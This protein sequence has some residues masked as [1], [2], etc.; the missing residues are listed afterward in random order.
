MSSYSYLGAREFDKS[1][2]PDSVILGTGIFGILT[3]S[4]PI[5]FLFLFEM[6]TLFIQGLIGRF[7]QSTLTPLAAQ[8]TTDQCKTG[9][10]AP[11]S[12]DRVTLLKLFGE[13][14]SFPSRP[15]FLLSSVFGYLISSLIAFQDVIRNLDNDF[16]MRLTL[17][18]VGTLITLGLVLVY[19]MRGGCVSFIGGMSTIVLGVMLGLVLM[20]LHQKFFGLEAVNFLGLPTIVSKTEK[21]SPLYVCAPNATS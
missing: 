7:S 16:Q 13:G 1:Y 10:F 3:L 12:R 8:Q 2:L 5:M 18:G 9:Y 19:Y 20:N 15:L 6:E 21:G 17:A 4:F 11:P 14:G